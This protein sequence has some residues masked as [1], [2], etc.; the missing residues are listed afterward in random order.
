VDAL[1][2]RFDNFMIEN[3][4]ESLLTEGDQEM[5][6]DISKRIIN[7]QVVDFFLE[8]DQTLAIELGN[9]VFI[10]FPIANL[11]IGVPEVH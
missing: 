9:G 6:D 2:A 7:Q 4:T 3:E 1:G 8:S 11:M 5:L 10:R